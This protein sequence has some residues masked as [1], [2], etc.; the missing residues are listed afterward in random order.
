VNE[1]FYYCAAVFGDGTTVESLT[2]DLFDS[3]EGTCA[4]AE[5][6]GHVLKILLGLYLI[7]FSSEWACVLANI[8]THLHRVPACMPMW[9]WRFPP[10]YRVYVA[11]RWISVLLHAATAIFLAVVS[12]AFAGLIAADCFPPDTI[13]ALNSIEQH[14]GMSFGT[15]IINML[16]GIT[17]LIVIQC[18]VL[19]H[20]RSKLSSVASSTRYLE[21]P[22]PA[23]KDE[24]ALI[25][26]GIMGPS[27]SG[28]RGSFRAG[29][30][31][32]GGSFRADGTSLIDSDDEGGRDSTE[33]AT[34]DRSGGLRSGSSVRG[35]ASGKSGPGG[36][37]TSFSE[38]SQWS[39][40][41]RRRAPLPGAVDETSSGGATSA[42]AARPLSLADSVRARTSLGRAQKH[43]LEAKRD[44]EEK[45]KP[46]SPPDE[47]VSFR[48]RDD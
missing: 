45:R 29:A 19:S 5:Q 34:A 30:D 25:E 37:I 6:S 11:F 42:E 28:P 15:C 2:V 33:L 3:C 22:P 7:V 46:R 18:G 27:S 47:A 20:R 10:S 16:V 39:R 44:E 9:E 21:P 32:S 12:S 23:A 41:D 40:R 26:A 13:F 4:D 17:N 31:G 8:C 24:R 14:L 38:F 36:D 35:G 43:L 1:T 48:D